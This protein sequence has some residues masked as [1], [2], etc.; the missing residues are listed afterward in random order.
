MAKRDA[1]LP[2]DLVG[3]LADLRIIEF[4]D[5]VAAVE[6]K[7][8]IDVVLFCELKHA[9]DLA[10]TIFVVTDTAADYRRAALET[11]DQVFIRTGDARTPIK[12]LQT[13]DVP[14][15]FNARKI[16]TPV[17]EKIRRDLPIEVD[18]AIKAAAIGRVYR[19]EMKDLEDFI[20]K[21]K[22]KVQ[23]APKRS[24]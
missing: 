7:I 2:A 15:M 12:A 20:Q 5:V 24:Y 16:L 11:I 23:R 10:G 4:F 14:Q 19:I 18:R 3:D 6:M 22:L 13:I 9:A 1:A 17:M 21:Q 8:D